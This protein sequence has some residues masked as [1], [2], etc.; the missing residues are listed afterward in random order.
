MALQTA[1]STDDDD[2]STSTAYFS[3]DESDFYI[4]SPTT[5]ATS[6]CS[7]LLKSLVSKTNLPTPVVS[8]G[9]TVE[10]IGNQSEPINPCSSDDFETII[11]RTCSALPPDSTSRLQT[12]LIANEVDLALESFD[13]LSLG[14]S[15][16]I[17][18]C[19]I[20][21]TLDSSSL[22]LSTSLTACQ[23]SRPIQNFESDSADSKVYS[24]VEVKDCISSTLASNPQA[25]VDKFTLAPSL[26]VNQG[27]NL[28]KT[29]S[30]VDY[31]PTNAFEIESLSSESDDSDHPTMRSNR[32]FR[33]VT[34]ISSES[35]DSLEI[36]ISTPSAQRHKNIIVISSDDDTDVECQQHL[37]ASFSTA[38]S[39]SSLSIPCLT[40]IKSDRRLA[41]ND[42]TPISSHTKK[43]LAANLAKNL[44]ASFRDAYI[45]NEKLPK[46]E[47]FE[48]DDAPESIPAQ[49]DIWLPHY[50]P[51]SLTKKMSHLVQSPSTPKSIRK[52]CSGAMLKNKE[53]LSRHLFCEFNNRVFES[54]LPDDMVIEWSVRLN[55][56]AGRTHTHSQKNGSGGW[57]R[58]A[59]IEL[60]S[61][62]LDTQDKLC[63]TL[64]HE[65]CHAACWVIDGDNSNPHGKLF[66]AWG[67]RAMNAY[68]HIKVSRCHS[69]DIAYK[70]TYSC[71][72][73]KCGRNYGR[74][75]KSINVATH[76]CGYCK[77][78]LILS[79]AN[80]TTG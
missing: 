49:H 10:F 50:S 67:D 19:N 18:S 76:G 21:N 34:A 69:Y 77:S 54:K 68:E 78:K 37:S 28:E 8:S 52:K 35:D 43:L 5:I 15:S 46:I 55:K 14:S 12:Q 58:I 24:N 13:K 26:D 7:F 23:T 11:P 39:I 31:D 62:V 60:A 75:S 20:Y 64:M 36:C 72:N 41:V 1:Y 47:S 71:T 73:V 45:D 33:R 48:T 2:C 63:N 40:Q 56:T 59:R 66:K 51:E 6:S 3:A 30:T 32:T 79:G 29:V 70:F 27:V 61:K 80:K 42:H 4:S 17:N 16:R 22:K 38:S 65:M 57:N 9:S 74:H 44:K 25:T 53:T